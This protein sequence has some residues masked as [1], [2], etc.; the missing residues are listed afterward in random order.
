[1]ID[2]EDIPL[3]LSLRPRG[4]LPRLANTAVTGWETYTNGSQAEGEKSEFCKTSHAF[5]PLLVDFPLL[6][7][8]PHY[9]GRLGDPTPYRAMLRSLGSVQEAHPAQFGEDGHKAS[10]GFSKAHLVHNPGPTRRETFQ[11]F[12]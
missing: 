9:L 2:G 4:S 7:N 10:A 5:I 1:M 12:R 8:F 6:V 11:R 3:K